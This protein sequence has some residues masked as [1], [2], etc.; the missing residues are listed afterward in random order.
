MAQ[1]EGFRRIDVA[2]ARDIINRG[3]ALVLDVRDAGFSYPNLVLLLVEL[4]GL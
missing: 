3:D 2:A 4:G 1:E